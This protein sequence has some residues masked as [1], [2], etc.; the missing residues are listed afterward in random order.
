MPAIWKYAMSPVSINQYKYAMIAKKAASEL[1]ETLNKDQINAL[2][3]DWVATVFIDSS[4]ESKEDV[5]EA[6]AVQVNQYFEELD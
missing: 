5:K 2:W 4:C 6:V 3:D 1:G